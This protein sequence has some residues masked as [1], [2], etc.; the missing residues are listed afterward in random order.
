MDFEKMKYWKVPDAI[1][2]EH[3][4]AFR[5]EQGLYIHDYK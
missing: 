4:R 2:I 1:G 3:V 5:Q